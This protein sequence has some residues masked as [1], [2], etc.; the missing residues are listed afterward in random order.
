MLGYIWIPLITKT[1]N[2]KH[3]SKIMFKC[4]NSVV[5]PSFK[6]F[7]LKKVLASL[8][9]N[10]WDPL[11]FSKTQER[12]EN[13]C[14]QRTLSQFKGCMS[15]GLKNSRE[16]DTFHLKLEFR[17]RQWHWADFSCSTITLGRLLLL[18]LSLSN[19]PSLFFFSSSQCKNKQIISTQMPVSL[20]IH[21]ENN[22]HGKDDQ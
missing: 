9:N 11:F 2:W 12:M 21:L 13:V 19:K 7:L 4:V 10:V 22:S 8:V 3:Y 18:S 17:R 1:E 20:S 14:S 5:R 16:I 15:N 6:F